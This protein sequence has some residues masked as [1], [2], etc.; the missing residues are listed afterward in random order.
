MLADQA[1]NTTI[2]P[3]AAGDT[4]GYALQQMV[5]LDVSCLPVID[6]TTGK[7]IGQLEKEDLL[8]VPEMEADI[9][10][11]ELQEP[12]KIFKS[13]HL[14]EAVRLM[15]QYEMRLLPVVDEEMIFLGIIQ[16]Q[17]LLESITGMMN[18]ASFGSILTVELKQEDFTL[19]E[20]VHL[21]EVEGARILGLAVETPDAE[22]GTFRVSV[23]INLE[24][25]TRVAS[26]LRRHDYNVVATE[27]A[28]DLFGLDMESRADE[29]L[30]YLDM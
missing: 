28:N 19:S 8:E 27:K 12:A 23:K 2:S 3:L 9:A 24:D 14:F 25:A 18:L 29:L 1:L 16:K 6:A 15:L 13:Q 20:I 17:Q 10:S 7:L 21:I 11:L 4:V 5:E 26:A 22:G 30:K